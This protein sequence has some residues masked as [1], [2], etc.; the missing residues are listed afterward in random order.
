MM[1]LPETR[2]TSGKS[3]K[4]KGAKVKDKAAINECVC[5]YGGGGWAVPTRPST[6]EGR[7][8]GKGKKRNPQLSFMGSLEPMTGDKDK[9]HGQSCRH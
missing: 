4:E 9:E 8:A 3:G 2:P 1:Q 6:T 5:V 7:L